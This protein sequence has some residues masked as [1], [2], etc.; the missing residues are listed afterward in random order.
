MRITRRQAYQAHPIPS[1]AYYPPEDPL[2]PE[3]TRQSSAYA[4][5]FEEQQDERV[6]RCRPCGDIMFESDIEEHECEE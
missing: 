1:H 2:E 6:F 3:I 5:S 4:E